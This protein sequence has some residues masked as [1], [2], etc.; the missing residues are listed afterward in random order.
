MARTKKALSKKQVWEILKAPPKT[1]S[2]MLIELIQNEMSEAIKQEID[3]GILEQ[4]IKAANES[5]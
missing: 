3:N 4:L 5:R 1:P 2:E